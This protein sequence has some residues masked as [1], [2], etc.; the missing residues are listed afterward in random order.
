MSNSLIDLNSDLKA[1]KEVGF[2]L[3]LRG[4]YLILKNVPYLCDA[5]GQLAKAD[6]V[7]SIE[8]ANDTT[9][10]PSDHT[11]WWTGRPPFRAD[12]SSMTNDLAC[13]IWEEGYDIG[14]GLTVFMQWSRMPLAD[15][16]KRGYKDYEEKMKTYIA[17]VADQ[18]DFKYPGVLETIKS[19]GE[20][21]KIALNT[22]FKYIDTNTYRYGLK[23][24]EQR[25]EDEVVA[26]V[27]VGGT[28]SYL[29]DILAKTNVKEIHLFD[30]DVLNQHNAF[31]MCGAA[32]IEQ[33]GG[34]CSKVEWY[35]KTY[36]AIREEGIFIYPEELSGSSRDLL[37]KFTTVFIAVDDLNVRRALQATC[38]ELG[39]YHISV[40]IGVEV[41][42]ENNDQLGGNV[43]IETAFRSKRPNTELAVP[44]EKQHQ[45]YGI[46]QNSELNML[47]AALAVIEWKAKV[48][49]YRNDRPK[50]M[51]TVLASVSTGKI[52]QN[53][54]GEIPN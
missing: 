45:A 20:D 39:I 35:R 36:S 15:G 48:G 14:E 52:L 10:A 28:G 51:D 50:E 53:Q 34:S 33:L 30:Q 2:S 27:G 19:D 7:T 1:L 26:I 6:I 24:I 49:I 37:K 11:V 54:N 9:T 12:G 5:K 41:E 40:G 8:L 42:G 29:M 38:N 46:I 16:N 3:E 4:A 18:A 17:E 32:S 23:G 44:E 47:G 22:R 25:I 13:S 31:R 43:K 21:P